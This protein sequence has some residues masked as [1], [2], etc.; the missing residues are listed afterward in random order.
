MGRGVRVGP[1][2]LGAV[3]ARNA[4]A[5]HEAERPHNRPNHRRMDSTPRSSGV[6]SDRL[7][8]QSRLP[9]L[10]FRE[11]DL[12]GLRRRYEFSGRAP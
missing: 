10:A 11:R 2:D 9:F 5:S 1:E 7:G 8:K 6:G 3:D 12:A 4:R